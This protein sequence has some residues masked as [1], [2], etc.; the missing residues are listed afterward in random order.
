MGLP[1]LVIGQSNLMFCA[2]GRAG[3]EQRHGR[4]RERTTYDHADVP[5]RLSPCM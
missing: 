1:V 5:H 3:G 4:S 2:G